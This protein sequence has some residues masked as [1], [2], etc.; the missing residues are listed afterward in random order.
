MRSMDERLKARGV[1]AALARGLGV[2]S[3]SVSRWIAQGCFP[4]ARCAEAERITGV[5][6]ETLNTRVRWF[7]VVEPG[8]PN[9]KPVADMSSVSAARAKPEGE[10]Q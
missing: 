8:W 10:S 4:A 7:R 3:P 1:N 9:G 6:A 5:P 2:R